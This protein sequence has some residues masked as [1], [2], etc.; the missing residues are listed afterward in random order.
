MSNAYIVGQRVADSRDASKI[1]TVVETRGGMWNDSAVLVHWDYLGYA[2]WEMPAHIR[3]A[4]TTKAADQLA[5]GDVVLYCGGMRLVIDQPISVREGCFHEQVY[6]TRARIA[7]WDELVA[8]AESDTSRKVG[9]SVAAFV[10]NQARAEMHHNRETEPRWTV[11][12]NHR[13]TYTVE[14]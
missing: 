11:Q 7:N 10:V 12:G 2:N 8:E 9:N 14:A 6:S 4:E 1:G 13:A 5:I 3:S